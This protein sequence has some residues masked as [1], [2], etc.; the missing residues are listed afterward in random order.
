MYI[1]TEV[2]FASNDSLLDA[3]LVQLVDSYTKE[4]VNYVQ[5]TKGFDGLSIDPSE[6]NLDGL[7]FRKR[8]SGKYY[9]RVF[10]NEI[11]VLWFKAALNGVVGDFEAL[12][13]AHAFASKTN[14]KTLLFPES[15]DLDLNGHVQGFSG[16]IILKFD[17][18]TIK[19]AI[20]S[21]DQTVVQAPPY[22]IFPGTTLVDRWKSSSGFAYPEWFGTIP[23]DKESVDLK[24]SV[25]KL[26]VFWNIKFNDGVYHSKK[27]E[28]PVLNFEG[29]AK[30]RTTIEICLD[31]TTENV[32][33]GLCLGEYEGLETKRGY[34]NVLKNIGI[35]TSSKVRKRNYSGV[36]IGNTH[37]GKIE[38]VV[39]N[40]S[41]VSMSMSK[42]DLL[43][44]L[45]DVENRYKEANIGLEFRGCS[46]LSMVND[47]ETLSDVGIGFNTVLHEKQTQGVDFPSIFNLGSAC[48]DFGLA[49]VFFGD[50]NVYNLTMDGIQ[51]WNQGMYGLYACKSKINQIDD[52]KTNWRSFMHCS[53][54]NVRIEQLTE[55]I[56]DS[57]GKI[58]ST[59]IYIDEQKF[60]D[61]FIFTNIRVAGNSNGIYLGNAGYGYIEFNNISGVALASVQYIIKTKHEH[62]S[63]LTIKL[64]NMTSHL[65]YSMIHEGGMV[66]DNHYYGQ[67][68]P[69]Y[70]ICYH[71]ATIIRKDDV[72][73]KNEFDGSK[74]FIQKDVKTFESVWLKLYHSRVFN[75]GQNEDFWSSHENSVSYNINVSSQSYALKIN[76][77]LFKDG[78]YYVGAYDTSK[79]FVG[80]TTGAQND[81][82]NIV[83]EAATGYWFINNTLVNEKIYC[84]I[85]GLIN[86]Q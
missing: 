44:V 82:I 27:G 22:Y 58:L 8:P 76:L 83:Y 40:N 21:G 37:C 45:I 32:K 65:P 48:G 19:N 59:S 17:G 80:D 42:D 51:S 61:N 75:S 15:C 4:N 54:N 67:S 68:M 31:T 9:K 23:Y 81:K 49:N 5:T 20:L 84:D 34:N 16:G 29:I 85:E 52:K 28:I 71:D 72:V 24:D 11:N 56:M 33:Y 50:T 66:I 77:I 14:H 53:I 26:K 63:C 25:E 39:I 43:S 74:R 69:K 7:I 79:I 1:E 70:N 60:I 86:Y 35:I 3:E 10:E 47:L 36:V 55:K 6:S 12:H 13:I 18:G 41:H 38:N 57:E 2:F 64:K 30:G 73:L 78:S 46:E 62:D